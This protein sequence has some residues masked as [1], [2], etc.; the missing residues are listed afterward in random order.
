MELMARGMTLSGSLVS[1]AAVPTS[2]IGRG[3]VGTDH[4]HAGDDQ[5]QDGD[6]LDDGEPELQLAE[7]F[8]GGQIQ[9]QQEQ[10]RHDRGEP[11]R[12]T[13]CQHLDVGGD[14]HDVSDADD[15]P[16]EP[17]GPCH[18]EAGPRAKKIPGKISEGLVVQVGEQDLPHGPH[19]EEQ[20][21]ADDHVDEEHSW[22]GQGDGLAGAHEQAGPDGTADGDH[23]DMTVAELAG[24]FGFF[25]V[26]CCCR[27]GDCGRGNL[28]NACRHRTF[29]CR[30]L[31][32]TKT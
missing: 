13:R 26:A 3:E 16:V 1:A 25:A 20:D 18:E 31:S 4:D 23:L 15:H 29:P 24:Q 5:R 7:R 27:F 8:D 14:R 2:S 9:A 6:H 21:E 11:Q 12:G 19:D 10:R 22:P 30:E 28:G 32:E 17:V